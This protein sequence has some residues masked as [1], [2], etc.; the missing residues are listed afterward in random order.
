MPVT[1]A[2]SL[3]PPLPSADSDALPH[4]EDGGPNSSSHATADTGTSRPPPIVVVPVANAKPLPLA[5]RKNKPSFWPA[6]LVM[7]AA[8]GGLLGVGWQA[9]R[10][11][12]KNT[13]EPRP[14]ATAEAFVDGL[15]RGDGTAVDAGGAEST[16]LRAAY[17]LLD[18]TSKERVSFDEFYEEWTRRGSEAG[19]FERAEWAGRGFR[20]ADADTRQVFIL[21]T[22]GRHGEAGRSYR[23]RVTLRQERGRWRVAGYSCE[24]QAGSK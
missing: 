16:G 24:P 3:P 8:T 19:F 11:N 20:G 9:V 18:S 5:K 6:I 22:A 15:V 21:S 7:I 1:S 2:G 10:R 17:E 14:L 12:F 23:L 13:N 4:G